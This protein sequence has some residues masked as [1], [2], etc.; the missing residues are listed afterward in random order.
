MQLIEP[1]LLDR[2]SD[3]ERRRIMR[4]AAFITDQEAPHLITWAA[5]FLR[6]RLKTY[7][8]ASPTLGLSDF[9]RELCGTLDSMVH[10]RGVK[11]C[12]LAPRKNAKSTF[13]TIAHPLREALEGREPYT[14]ILSDA[15]EKNAIPFLRDNIKFEIETNKLL[16]TAY[17][18][19]CKPGRIWQEDKIE[20]AN[21]CAIEVSS[22]G[23]NIRGRLHHGNPPS[24]AIG[25]DMQNDKDVV[26]PMQRQHAW[27]WFNGQVMNVGNPDTNFLMLG[28]AIHRDCIVYGL[29]AVPGWDVKLWRALGKEQ[30]AD[31]DEFSLKA[32]IEHPELWDEWE[33]IL[34]SGG[35]GAEAKARA[36]Y[37]ERQEAMDAGLAPFVLWPEQYPLYALMLRLVS[38]GPASFASEQQNN[39]SDPE[40]LEWPADYFDEKARPELRFEQWNVPLAGRVLYLDPAKGT[41]NKPGD[42]AC[43]MRFGWAIAPE[44]VAPKEYYEADLFR[45]SQD[46]T[47]TAIGERGVKHAREFKPDVV[48]VEVTGQQH[49]YLPILERVFREAGI[50]VRVW[51]MEDMTDKDVRIRRL[52]RPLAQRLACFR[53]NRGTDMLL[54]QLRDFPT[55]ERK[56][57]PDA[58][59]GARR[60]GLQLKVGRGRGEPVQFRA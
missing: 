25:D 54:E 1:H 42:Y 7:N 4:L 60:T 15:L 47:Q 48:A 34:H 44:G 28:T 8:P 35:V 57:G 51:G 45:G 31:A 38:I 55:H 40:A 27:T 21:G 30:K 9:Q 46:A 3:E 22:T 5:R 16:Q 52:E 41:K 36:F 32:T 26:S 14:L 11:R 12:R 19:S 56:D 29:R 2:A 10:A 13:A 39:P 6:H 49:L 58:M 24:L 18:H 37:L 20:L 33:Y 23:Q 59:E 43:W 50:D 17:P 53:R